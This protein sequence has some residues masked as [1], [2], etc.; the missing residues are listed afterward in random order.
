MENIQ[1]MTIF[2]PTTVDLLRDSTTSLKKDDNIPCTKPK[3]TQLDVFAQCHC[4]KLVKNLKLY[5][6]LEVFIGSPMTL[7]NPI[8]SLSHI[9][10]NYD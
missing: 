10:W 2:F 4:T 8:V 9:L 6:A 5:Q 7:K 1:N 3:K